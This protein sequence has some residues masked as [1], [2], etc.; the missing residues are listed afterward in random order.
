MRVLL[1]R[2][3]FAILIIYCIIVV[4]MYIYQKNLIFF[5]Q[6]LSSDALSL[7]HG[8]NGVEEVTRK[9]KDNTN[10]KGWFVTGQVYGKPGLL[11]Y[12]GGNAEEVS[13]LIEDMKK[14]KGWNVV[15]MNYRGYGQSEGVPGEKKLF[16]DA[17]EIYDYF[18]AREKP[19]KI[20]VMG[21]SLGTGVA[22][23]LAA[24]RKVNGVVLVSP[25][26]S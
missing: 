23:Y 9:M 7:M 22:T 13:W 15:L 12:Y 11:I 20:A 4:V 24:N 16:S 5:P 19:G 1:T 17:L 6:S 18:A 3:L 26:D 2:G 10:L 8:Q 25:Y 21:R 14:L